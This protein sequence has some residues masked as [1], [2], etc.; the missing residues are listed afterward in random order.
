MTTM[1]VKGYIENL[2][3][4][5]DSE[6]SQA[7]LKCDFDSVEFQSR[8]TAMEFTMKILTAIFLGHKTAAYVFQGSA[9]RVVFS[10]LYPASFDLVFSFK[11]VK[12]FFTK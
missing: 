9:D 2:A 3:D 8:I 7:I 5:I 12:A 1:T 11:R 4:Q 10:I 6:H